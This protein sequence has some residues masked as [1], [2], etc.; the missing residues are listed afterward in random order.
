MQKVLPL[1]HS[2]EGTVEDKRVEANGLLILSEGHA[3]NSWGILNCEFIDEATA[4]A[5]KSARI[6]FR[7]PCP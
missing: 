6:L 7:R 4:E 3:P 5:L 2:L 1:V